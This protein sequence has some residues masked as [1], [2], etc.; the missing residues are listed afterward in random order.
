MR[1]RASS[2]PLPRCLSS[3]SGPPMANAWLT[4]TVKSSSVSS[5]SWPLVMVASYLARAVGIY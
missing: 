5:Q 4:S 2:L 3:R 1:A